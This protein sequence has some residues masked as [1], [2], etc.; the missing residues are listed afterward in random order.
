ML[1]QPIAV[2]VKK[3]KGKLGHRFSPC[4]RCIYK[5]VVS[6]KTLFG[7]NTHAIFIR[8]NA[9]HQNLRSG[10]G[11]PYTEYIGECKNFTENIGA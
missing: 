10:Q 5:N 11:Q 3:I 2:Q 7:N 4:D 6:N 1:S 9:F 8:T